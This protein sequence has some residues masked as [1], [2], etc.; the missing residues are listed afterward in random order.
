MRDLTKGSVT[1][2]VLH[3]S[4]FLGV[5]MLFQTL[6]FLVDL[7]F[8]SG[9]GKTAIA[10][11]GLSGNLMMV[12]MALTQSLSVGTTSLVARAAGRRDREDAQTVFNQ[13]C[14]LS[15]CAGTAVVIAA[16]AFSAAYCRALSADEETFAQGMA[17]LKWYVP[18]LGM[19]FLLISMGA[20]L[21]GT[22]IVKP[23]MIMGVV[24]VSSNIVLA[25]V[26]VAGWGT[27]RPLGVEGAALATLASV[28]VALVVL[29]L[30]FKRFGT[31]VTFDRT[32]LRPRL[33]VWRRILEI[34][35]PSGGEFA[36]LGLYSVVVYRVIRDFGSE[37][38]AGF[39]IGVRVVQ[40]MFLPV[41]AISFSATPVAGQ[42]Y[43]ARLPDRV[44]QTF[45]TAATMGSSL[46]LALTVLCLAAPEPLVRAFTSE[47]MVIAHGVDYLRIVCWSFAASAVIFT[48]SGMF[49]A[50][51]NTI[52]PLM[53]SAARLTVFIPAAAW[54]AASPGFRLSHLWWLATGTGILQAAVAVLL[55]QREFG[56]KLS[57]EK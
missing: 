37:A 26:L 30:L 27:G 11:V 8:V 57:F 12:V 17:Y 28:T 29:V 9:L 56:R 35:L 46:M 5:T 50:M 25:P 19:Q 43:G 22:G 32:R 41:L 52:P 13:S 21:R 48:S 3:L 18:S 55:L 14:V 36:L 54:L 31:F 1:G 20:A 2:H 40:S 34:G 6:Y 10:G 24:S 7:Y 15:A 53:N 33:G 42:N 39:G 38:Q 4:A 45:R 47:P 44:R 23:T 16:L 51:G 49:Q